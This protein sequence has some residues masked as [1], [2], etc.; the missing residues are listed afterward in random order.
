[1]EIESGI[2][3]AT[4]EPIDWL[5]A[6]LWQAL[7][8][9]LEYPA[10][11]ELHPLYAALDRLMS[12]QS[13]ARQ[14]QIAGTVL[15]QLSEIYAARFELSISEWE[16]QHQPFEP[17]VSLESC[18]DLF[19]QSLSLNLSELFEVASPVQYPAHRK[20]SAEG[21]RVAA[22]DKQSLLQL[23]DQIATQPRS[24]SWETADLSS[25]DLA[26][27]IQH[28]AHDENVEQWSV[29]IQDFLMASNQPQ[30]NRLF[31][32][33]QRLNMPLIELWLGLLLG[34]YS[35]EQRGDFY[36][37]QS[38]WVINSAYRHRP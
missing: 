33:Q 18:V 22:V 30:G 4:A 25:V 13:L 3:P 28:L 36:D 10:T 26:A 6:E 5:K 24:E 31:D 23:A 15:L 37:S 9:A 38:I 19:V 1:L 11:A 20:R 34:G 16:R 14:L 8:V 12:G 35:L 2:N 7:A 29:S 32:I 27:Q 17:I 21:S